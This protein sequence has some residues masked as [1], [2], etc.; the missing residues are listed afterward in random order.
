MQCQLDFTFINRSNVDTPTLLHAA[1]AL[2]VDQKCNDETVEFDIDIMEKGAAG[3]AGKG[4]T[5]ST[6][7]IGPLR[8]K[9]TKR[10][11]ISDYLNF[12]R[13]HAANVTPYTDADKL[14]KWL[15]EYHLVVEFSIG[16]GTDFVTVHPNF[17]P[18]AIQQK[19]VEQLVGRHETVVQQ[20]IADISII[21]KEELDTIWEWNKTV[22]GAVDRHVDQIV[23]EW[24]SST[25]GAQAICAW[26][27]KATYRELDKFITPLAIHLQE[28]GVGP[29]V[30]V[31]LCFEKSMWTT[32]A[33]L[34][35][36]KAGGAF[37]LLGHS[38]SDQELQDIVL[39]VNAKL[40]LSSSLKKSLLSYVAQDFTSE[41]MQVNLW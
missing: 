9:M 35:V 32:V 14:Q 12:L 19:T 23:A 5:N 11:S 4:K 13:Q 39:Q 10:Q 25:P 29:E 30:I 7:A 17:D 38:I 2:V 40:I 1:W 34:A 31:P 20:L 3:N 24:A 37:V 8:I 41:H 36:M 6:A 15:A 33:M 27:G 28:L 22:P 18:K 26:D 16:I 21:S